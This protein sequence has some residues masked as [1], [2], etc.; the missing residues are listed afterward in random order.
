MIA[1]PLTMAQA[2][3]TMPQEDDTMPQADE[4]AVV[5]DADAPDANVTYLTLAWSHNAEESLAGYILYYGRASGQYSRLITATKTTATLGVRG[6][7]TTFFAVTAFNANGVESDF[8][9]EVQ[10]P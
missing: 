4:V 8:S 10:W 2:D 6:N 5:E 3:D 1:L 9:E 7:R